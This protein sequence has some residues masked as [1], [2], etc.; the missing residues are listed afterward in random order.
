MIEFRP[1]QATH[2]RYLNPQRLQRT[3]H[4]VLLNPEYAE[5]VDRNFALSAWVGSR[6][7]GASGCVPVFAQ[8]AVGWAIL[9]EDAAPY[10][11][12]IIRRFRDVISGL[13]YRRIEI[14]V[15]ADFEDGKRFAR[16]IG[17]KLETPEPMRAHGPYGEDEL[18]YAAVKQ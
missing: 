11:L 3:D 18:Q 10:M 12:P 16:L 2:L 8:R 15:R 6:C 1:F 4:A 14:C 17:M 13:P 5:I 7:V 9:S